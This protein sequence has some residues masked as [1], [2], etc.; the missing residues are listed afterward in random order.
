VIAGINRLFD[1]GGKQYHL[2]AEDLGEAQAAFEVRV[3]DQGTVL[4]KKRVAYEDV[5][6]RGLP[7][8]EQDDELRSMMEKALHTVEAAIVRGKLL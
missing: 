2:Q 3:F 5:L 7:R 6:A 4:W 1:H 8:L